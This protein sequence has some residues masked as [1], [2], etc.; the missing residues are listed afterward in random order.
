[1]KG[2]CGAAG[3]AF[4]NDGVVTDS[5]PYCVWQKGDTAPRLQCINSV[6]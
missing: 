6:L 3:T 2:E 4:L 5:F 1:M